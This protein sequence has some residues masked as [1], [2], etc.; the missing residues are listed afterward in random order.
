[1]NGMTEPR[2][3]AEPSYELRDALRAVLLFHGGGE[4]D[5][6]KRAEW[7]RITGSSEAT[8]KVLCDHIRS[9][10]ELLHEPC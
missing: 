2:Y 5:D 3:E 7:R 1:M 6:A 9:A 8:T 10:L 4:W